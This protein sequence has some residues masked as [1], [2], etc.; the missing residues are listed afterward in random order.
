MLL[1]YFSSCAF[2]EREDLTLERTILS[3]KKISFVPLDIDYMRTKNF[4]KVWSKVYSDKFYPYRK[5]LKKEFEI[6]GQSKIEG[7]NY[8][9]IKDHKNKLFKS[10][11]KFDGKGSILNSNYILLNDDYVK[12]KDLINKFIWLNFTNNENIFFTYNTKKF[13]RFDKVKV[14]DVMKFQNSDL[15]LPLWLIIEGVGGDKGF[16][17]YD[18]SVNNTGY[19][20][21]YFIED[22]L[23]KE[24]G[25]KTISHIRSGK[26]EI[27][28]TKRQV[29]TSIGNPEIINHTSSR[30]GIS[31]QWIY[32]FKNSKKQF[33]QFED[34]KL[35]YINK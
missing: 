30:H 27:G 1:I 3:G 22:P 14:I 32:K 13:L 10:K 33:Y 29:R 15:K 9:I 20:D 23:P 4:N 16:L 8:T 17:R 7:V 35:I 2:F 34:G 28:M 19:Q 21:H 11:L 6:Q 26:S 12:A 24:W 25:E 31:E 5:L 18:R